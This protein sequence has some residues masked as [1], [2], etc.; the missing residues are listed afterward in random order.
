MNKETFRWHPTSRALTLLAVLV[1][2]LAIA[3]AAATYLR[4]VTNVPK[5]AER[6]EIKLPPAWF[7]AASACR[8][9]PSGSAAQ[10]IAVVGL[11]V[12]GEVGRRARRELL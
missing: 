2:A 6:A 12:G 1:P 10:S 5:A 3:G 7:P 11:A 8:H 4:G 9:K